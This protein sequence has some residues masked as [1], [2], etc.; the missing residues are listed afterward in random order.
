M[1]WR[2]WEENIRNWQIQLKHDRKRN[3]RSS[4][5]QCSPDILTYLYLKQWWHALKNRTIC[6]TAVNQQVSPMSDPSFLTRHS[7]YSCHCFSS[8]SPSLGLHF[9]FHKKDLG[10]ICSPSLWMPRDS[11]LMKPLD[12]PIQSGPAM[13]HLNSLQ[14]IAIHVRT[15]F[16]DANLGRCITVKIPLWRSYRAHTVPQASDIL[17]RLL[18]FAF[19]ADQV[20][21]HMWISSLSWY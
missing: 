7:C 11:N 21:Q 16:G 6:M 2:S 9:S 13:I 15:C 12:P 20:L 8:I 10:I 3:G 14:F 17:I 19:P 18:T 5:L 1:S 4:H